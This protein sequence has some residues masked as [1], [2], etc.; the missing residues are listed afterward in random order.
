MA[1]DKKGHIFISY[2]HSDSKAAD[3]IVA[4]LDGAGLRVWLDRREISPGQSFVGAMNQGLA[5]ASY[6][7]FLASPTSVASHWVETEWTSALAK[8]DIVVVPV[9]VAPCEMPPLMRSLVYIDMSKDAQH[10]INELLTFLRKEQ[11]QAFTATTSRGTALLLKSASRRE[12]RLVASH[13]M[14]EEAFLSF[15]LDADMSPNSIPGSSLNE[16]MVHLLH[17]MNKDGLIEHF[18]EWLEQERRRCVKVQLEKVRGE[19]Q[20]NMPEA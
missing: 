13:C 6:L 16:R 9:K 7:L 14:D 11:G 5:D 15:L 10:G 3:Q 12:I 1:D 2:S 19:M 4:A 17:R 8:R 18:A 20:W